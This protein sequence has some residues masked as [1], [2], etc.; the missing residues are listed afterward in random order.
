MGSKGWRSAPANDKERRPKAGGAG[1]LEI[2]LGAKREKILICPAPFPGFVSHTSGRNPLSTSSRMVPC[3]TAAGSR[4]QRSWSTAATGSSGS[5]H[6]MGLSPRVACRTEPSR[7][8]PRVAR[9][10]SR[11]APPP[12]PRTR[13][14]ALA[15]AAAGG[16][17]R[18]PAWQARCRMLAPLQGAQAARGSS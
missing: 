1:K 3:P 6:V 18:G 14:S 11:A 5:G 4:A 8:V 12:Q 16:Q 9:V 2:E 7:R 13:Q 10:G 15:L 17:A